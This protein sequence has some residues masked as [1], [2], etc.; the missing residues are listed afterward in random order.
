MTA[1]SKGAR[2]SEKETGNKRKRLQPEGANEGAAAK[3][4]SVSGRRPQ[5]ELPK[6]G[7][8]SIKAALAPYEGRKLVIKGDA[9]IRAA[10]PIVDGGKVEYVPGWFGV[11]PMNRPAE[12]GRPAVVGK[13]AAVLRLSLIHISEP[14]RPY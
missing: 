8:G 3:R 14:T 11:A 12:P 7:P 10:I 1:N 2:S 13:F 5:V 9:A 4:K 6:D